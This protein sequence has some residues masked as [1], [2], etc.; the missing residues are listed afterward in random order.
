MRARAKLVEILILVDQCLYIPLN[1]PSKGDFSQGIPPL[2]GVFGFHNENCCSQPGFDKE[3][4]V[5]PDRLPPASSGAH[6]CK[7]I[8]QVKRHQR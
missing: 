1:P 2:R 3:A 7:V 5:E 8:S 4:F 6:M